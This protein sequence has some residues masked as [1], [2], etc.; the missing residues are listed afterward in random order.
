MKFPIIKADWGIDSDGFYIKLYCDKKHG[1]ILDELH[2]QTDC[3]LKPHREK[4][5]RNAND[6]C[7]AL[8]GKLSEKLNMPPIEIYRE[9]VKEVGVF[10]DFHLTAADNKT[11]CTLWRKQGL[12]WLTE[13][14]DYEPDGD[15]VVTRCWY[16]SSVYNTKQMSRLIDLIVQECKQQGIE[17][18]T[19]AEQAGMLERWELEK[20]K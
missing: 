19:P 1:A 18:A 10:R 13:T 9:M 3:E 15:N 4:R 17:T 8:I 16:G 20:K 11:L 14:L 6:Y 2:G 12:A 5:S 7:W